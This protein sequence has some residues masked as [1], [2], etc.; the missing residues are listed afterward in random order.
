MSTI[1]YLFIIQVTF[2][3]LEDLKCLFYVT[4]QEKPMNS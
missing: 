2:E 4:D 3:P 1:L